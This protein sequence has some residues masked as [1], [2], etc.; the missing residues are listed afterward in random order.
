MTTNNK[1]P[2]SDKI[3]IQTNVARK[4]YLYA[5]TSKG[6]ILLGTNFCSYFF[7]KRPFVN[8]IYLSTVVNLIRKNKV[9]YYI[10]ET[11]D[12]PIAVITIATN[13]KLIN[14]LKDSAFIDR[15]LPVRYGPF[16]VTSVS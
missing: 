14:D 6:E 8:K 9:A 2:K 1:A 16:S 10:L 5:Y 4:Y 13:E 12:K 3:P 15:N 11:T 7:C